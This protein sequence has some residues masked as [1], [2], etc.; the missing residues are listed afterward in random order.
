MGLTSINV[1]DVINLKAKSQD[2]ALAEKFEAL[3]EENRKVRLENM[4]TSEI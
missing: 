1:E 2:P 4:N 3:L